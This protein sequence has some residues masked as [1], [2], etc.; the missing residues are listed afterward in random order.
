MPRKVFPSDTLAYGLQ[1]NLFI[2]KPGMKVFIYTDILA[3]VLADIQDMANGALAGSYVVVDSSSQLPL[4][5]GPNTNVDT[6]YGKPEG[7][8]A[9]Q[10]LYARV[11]DRLDVLE[12]GTF[13]RTARVYRTALQAIPNATITPINFDAELWDTNA[14][15]DTV[16]NPS[17]VILNKIGFWRVTGSLEFAVIAAGIRQARINLNNVLHSYNA[18]L[19]NAVNVIPVQVTADIQITAITDYVE[20]AAYQ[21]SGGA[22]NVNLGSVQTWLS[23]TFLGN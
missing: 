20:L 7:G 18:S 16:T 2:G 19:A 6:L 23:A 14:L 5:Q 13:A 10:P 3:T 22:L 21:D 4:F 9:V 8:G 15:H 17:R 1:G 12:A 11:D